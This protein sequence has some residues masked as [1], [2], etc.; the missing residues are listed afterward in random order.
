MKCEDVRDLFSEYYDDA[1][2][3]AGEITLHLERCPDCS[4]EFE[5]YSKLVVDVASIKEPEVPDGFHQALVSYV[6][7]F[8]R[9]RKRHISIL[10]HRFT[11]VF[12]S[13]AAAAAAMLFVW[14][15]GIFDTGLVVYESPQMLAEFAA[16]QA[17]AEDFYQS[18]Y[19]YEDFPLARHFDF[20]DETYDFVMGVFDE[21]YPYEWHYVQAYEEASPFIAPETD[22]FAFV[23]APFFEPVII[24]IGYMGRPVGRPNFTTAVVFLVIGLFLGYQVHRLVKYLE[25]KSDNAP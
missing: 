12:A 25:R 1:T 15:T 6:D 9:G 14:F 21:P 24:E 13:M 20:D 4:N 18:W 16:P 2:K 11:S 8:Y 3:Q 10:S 23:D 5:A 7:G 22:D 19:V 17:A